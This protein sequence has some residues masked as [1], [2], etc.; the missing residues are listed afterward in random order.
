MAKMTKMKTTIPILIE[1]TL[2]IRRNEKGDSPIVSSITRVRPLLDDIDDSN[3]NNEKSS[4]ALADIEDDDIE[5]L[6]ASS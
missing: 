3:Y 6:A 4:S 5:I 1:T 2:L